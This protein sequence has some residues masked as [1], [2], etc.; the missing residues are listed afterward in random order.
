M[1]QELT[2]T[3]E[4]QM[5]QEQQ[6][7]LNAQQVMVIRLL[8]MPIAQLEQNVQ[9]EMDENPALEAKSDDMDNAIVNDIVHDNDNDSDSDSSEEQEERR[10]ELD[11]VLDRMDRDDRMETANYDRN[12]NNDP[13]ADQE[14]R[15]FGNTESFYDKLHE[16]MHEHS[17]T[18]RQ[19]IIM[20]Y[21]IGNL[22]SDGL[23]RKDLIQLSDEIAVHEY[24]DE[25]ED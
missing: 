8:E 16:Q 14:E 1:A 22:D 10:D 21:L 13:D 24:I 25:S 11:E 7:R 17:L 4:Q 12:N 20:E 23:L 15:I 18:E 2:Q 3:Q 5:V 19:E 9:T 6:Q